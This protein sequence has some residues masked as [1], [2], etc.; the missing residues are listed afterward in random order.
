MKHNEI[1]GAVANESNTNTDPDGVE[2]AS[3][4]SQDGQHK[5]SDADHTVEHS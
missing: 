5:S 1:G 3:G 4:D 2:I